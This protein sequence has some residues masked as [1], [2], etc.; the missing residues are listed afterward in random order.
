ML[1]VHFNYCHLDS[2]SSFRSK[3]DEERIVHTRGT[4]VKQP[5][6]P[7]SGMKKTLP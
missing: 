3:L 5:A 7:I 6:Y 2:E 4:P 1:T